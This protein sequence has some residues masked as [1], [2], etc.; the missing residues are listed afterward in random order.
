MNVFLA[1]LGDPIWQIGGGIILLAAPVLILAL[2]SPDMHL[3]PRHQWLWT[4]ITRFMCLSLFLMLSTGVVLFHGVNAA[5]TVGPKGSQPSSAT[6]SPHGGSLP[7]PSS[8]ASL[9]PSPSPTALPRLASSPAQ[10]LTTFCAAINQQDVNTAWGQYAQ[11]LQKERTTPPLFLVRITLVHCRVA[12]V[13]DTS[14]IGYLFFKTI[15][16]NG[17][18][19]DYERLF[20]L[21]LGVEHGAWKITQIARCLP[22]GCLPNTTFVVP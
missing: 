17:Y 18:T 14:A 11:A 3:S 8:T 20:Q 19:D 1:T 6:A 4:R 16:P 9:I 13:S 12:Q 22:D 21:T 7:Q 10:V 5:P 2:R 15:G